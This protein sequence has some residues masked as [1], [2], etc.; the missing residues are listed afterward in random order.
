MKTILMKIRHNYLLHH[1]YDS[2]CIILLMV[3]CQYHAYHKIPVGE[4]LSGYSARQFVARAWNAKLSN[5]CN[6]RLYLYQSVLGTYA[7][8]AC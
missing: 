6:V 3:V 8:I 2:L 5:D 1:L 7:Y 4:V